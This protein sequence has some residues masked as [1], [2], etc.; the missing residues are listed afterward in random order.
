M[1]AILILR[2]L[3]RKLATYDEEEDITEWLVNRKRTRAPLIE[4]DDEVFP[5]EQLI[6]R[7]IAKVTCANPNRRKSLRT[8]IKKSAPKKK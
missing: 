4:N 5:H 3:I 2:P 1:I 7:Q 8:N 6:W